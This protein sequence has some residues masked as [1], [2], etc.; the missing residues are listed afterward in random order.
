MLALANLAL[1]TLNL[2]NVASANLALANEALGKLALAT[3]AFASL[4]LAF[5]A[6]SNLVSAILASAHLALA[7]FVLGHIVSGPFALGNLQ[8][9]PRG[10]WGKS[11]PGKPGGA[12]AWTLYINDKSKN[13]Y[14]QS[15]VREKSDIP[16]KPKFC[17]SIYIHIACTYMYPRKAH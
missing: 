4:A 14:E 17:I 15:S 5:V 7:L 8:G 16:P 1:M 10:A 9:E 11:W 13:P 6:S 12:T 3:L 2:V